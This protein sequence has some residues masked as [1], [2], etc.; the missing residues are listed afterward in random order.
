VRDAIVRDVLSA[1]GFARHVITVELSR[2]PH[3]TRVRRVLRMLPGDQD[4]CRCRPE[5]AGDA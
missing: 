2:I 5:E 1:D 3:A 4:A